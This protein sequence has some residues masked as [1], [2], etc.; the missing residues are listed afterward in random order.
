MHEA[1]NALHLVGVGE[2]LVARKIRQERPCNVWM[3]ETL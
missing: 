3:G 2:L 1:D